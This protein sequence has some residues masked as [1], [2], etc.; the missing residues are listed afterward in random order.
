MNGCG[1][2]IYVLR[3]IQVVVEDPSACRGTCSPSQRMQSALPAPRTL[4]GSVASALMESSKARLIYVVYPRA[5]WA[6][7]FFKRI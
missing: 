7:T 6:I 2:A 5:V 4:Q 1:T 3:S